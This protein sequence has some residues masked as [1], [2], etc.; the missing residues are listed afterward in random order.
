[1]KRRVLLKNTILIAGGLI[2]LPSWASNWSR[3]TIT[4][5]ASFLS[6]NAEALL[7]EIVNTIIPATDTPGAKELGVDSLIKKILED[8]Y[9]K[10]VQEMFAKGLEAVGERSNKAF[11][12]PFLD[13]NAVERIEV[14]KQFEKSEQQTAQTEAPENIRSQQGGNRQTPTFFR[15]LKD[16]TILGYTNSEYVMTNL[17]GYVAVPG[18][19]HGCVPYTSKKSA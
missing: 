12:K 5:T 4:S 15:L 19:Y 11:S 7:A 14:L 8:C 10:D 16:L 18:H 9:P 2:A 6:I 1:M 3:Q 13:A 17:T